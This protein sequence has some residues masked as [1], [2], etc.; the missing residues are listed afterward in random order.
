MRETLRSYLR[1]TRMRAGALAA[2][3]FTV[4]VL[5][6]GRHDLRAVIGWWC[7]GLGYH[8]YA[9]VLNDLADLRTDRLDRSR[10]SAPLVSGAMTVRQASFAAVALGVAL[11]AAESSA[12]ASTRPPVTALLVLVTYGNLRQKRSRWVPPWIMDA[13]F[14]VA[15][16]GPI[17]AVAASG[18]SGGAGLALWLFAAG[19]GVQ[20]DLFNGVA[21]NLKDLA[22]DRQV[23]ARTTAL[24]LGVRPDGAGVRFTATYRA[25][26][27]ALLVLSAAASVGA[28]LTSAG[29][30]A[31]WPLA[32]SVAILQ[33][34]SLLS[35]WRLLT[36][37]R[38]PLRSGRDPFLAGQ[39]LGVFVVLTAFAGVT[40]ASLLLIVVVVWT[41]SFPVIEGILAPATA[42]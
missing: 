18:T 12:P 8:A 41:L 34:I 15:M 22:H 9:C 26:C 17:V 4:G 37:V 13:L 29:G 1:L 35:L 14:G 11:V 39:F 30:P 6:T 40:S 5:A 32:G 27:V 3:P 24:V 28:V 25:Y 38:P 16:A 20:M 19:F 42:S 10:R 36:G 21:G 31:A 7:F 2:F 33:T 23:G